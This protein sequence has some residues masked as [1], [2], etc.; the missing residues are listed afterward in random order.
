MTGCGGGPL[1]EQVLHLAQLLRRSGVDVS[2]GE[3]I[4][5]STALGHLDLS[6]RGVVRAGLRATLV[7]DVAGAERFD[8]LFDAAFRADPDRAPSAVTAPTAERASEP[9]SWA[10]GGDRPR[11]LPDAV[12]AAL[13]AGN[14]EQLKLLAADAVELHA[15]LADAEG[16]ERYFLHRVLRALDLSRMLSAAM[17]QLRRDGELSEL[18][19]TLRRN[20]LVGLLEEFRRQLAAELT[21][22]LRP[23]DGVGPPVGGFPDGLLDRD[24]RALSA[25]ELVA[26]R[27]AVQPLAR[28]LATRIGRRRRA[29]TT[30]RLDIRRTLRRSMSS[31]G[32]PVDVQLRRRHPH[33]PEILLLC[34]VSGSVAHYA[35]FTF[36]L[37]HALHDELRHVRSFA[38][39][40]GVAEVTDLFELAVHDIPVTRLVERP[41]VIRLDGHSDYG[42]VFRCFADQFSAAVTPRTTVIVLGD[43]RTNHRDPGE[44]AFVALTRRARR[45]YWLHPEPRAAWDDADAAMAAYL[46]HCAGAFEVRSLRQLGDVV[47]QLV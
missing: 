44:D 28:R 39:V 7:K 15:G 18:E 37:V 11:A 33:R 10:D 45:V 38:F 8:R 22:R 40:D 9:S 16:G 14:V 36:A 5:A 26:L 12:L 13:A 6:D 25:G 27:R 46:P 19:L 23:R 24:L 1:L 2:T 17:Q 4:D 42:A 43:A 20:E 31:G 21:V 35:R 41:G 29:A 32:V 47:A 3:V 34:D 30:G